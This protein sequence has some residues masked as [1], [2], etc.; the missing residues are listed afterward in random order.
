MRPLSSLPQLQALPLYPH[1]RP[2][3]LQA[4]PT[5]LPRLPLCHPLQTQLRL[6]Y[7]LHCSK[8]RLHSMY[9]RMQHGRVN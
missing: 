5:P 3:L 8:L 1:P 7:C 6:P 9:M 2:S 4:Q